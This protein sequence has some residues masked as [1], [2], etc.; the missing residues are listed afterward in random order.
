M[1]D[2][3]LERLHL[4]LRGLAAGADPARLLSDVL[5]GALAATGAREG[6][7][8]RTS[9]DRPTVVATT[10]QVSDFLL[11]AAKEAA[12]A[13]R[14]QRA[15]DAQSGMVAVAEPLRAGG[16]V[17]GVLAVAGNMKRLDPGLLPLYGDATT[18]VLDRRTPAGAGELP[19]V[20]QTLAHIGADVDTYAILSR[21]F[22]ACQRL[23]GAASGF[24]ALF[25]D[26]AVRVGHYRGID[27]E[28]LLRASRHPEFRGLLLQDELRVESADHPV[29]A[30]LARLGEV[31]MGV[32]LVVDGRKVGHLVLL[33]PAP[34]DAGRRSVLSAFAAHAAACLRSAELYR[35][36]GDHEEQ[37]GA[38]VHSMPN[39][40]VV[41]D[42]SG[43]LV[44]VNGAAGELFGIDPGFSGEL[45]IAGRLGHPRL[46]AMLTGG[47][48]AAEE[49]VLGRDEQRVYRATVRR[50][51]SAGGRTLG[52]ILVLDDLTSEREADALKADFVAVIGHELRTPLTVM[53]GYM[54]TLT[55]RWETLADDKR[56]QA[57]EALS[58]NLTRLE[59]LIEDLLFVSAIEQRRCKVDLALHDLGALLEGFGGERVQVHRPRRPVEI[60]LDDAKVNQVVHHLVDNALKYSDGD[61]VVELVDKGEVV[62]VSVTDS[63]P[64]IYSGDIPQ[65]F[66]RFRQLDGTSTR[67]HGGVGIGLYL[68]RRL[69]EALG[70]RI[71]CESRLGVGSRFAFT[72]PKDGPPAPAP[73]AGAVPGLLSKA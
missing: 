40:V 60:E 54:H 59:R 52:R 39:P 1:A 9:A 23:F 5:A 44:E 33:L 29:V 6:L 43:R 32:P 16:R 7:V 31:A 19:D 55:K 10:G 47:D 69:I 34:L 45:N 13:D 15:R 12:G 37:L 27:H 68:S 26:G 51:R 65:L 49:I 72:L 67:A 63:G 35:R 48:D 36:L 53:K 50:A 42:E 66:E 56:G 30:Q 20:L 61:V 73:T 17:V 4:V 3:H 58:G 57:L 41:V 21:I 8:L 46:E 24:C 2:S 11:D 22:D 70:G 25:Q 38:I 62:E 71:W 14:L 64:G 28:R 18:L